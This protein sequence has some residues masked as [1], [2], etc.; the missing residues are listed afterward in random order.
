MVIREFRADDLSAALDL[1]NRSFPTRHTPEWWKWKYDE[2][3]FGK[4]IVLVAEEDGHVIGLRG[5]WR[6]EFL[7]QGQVLKTVQS[8][9]TCVDGEYRRR[10]IF[11][12]LV[13]EALRIAGC[14]GTQFVYNFPGG[15]SLPGYLKLGWHYVKKIGWYVRPLRSLRTLGACLGWASHERCSLDLAAPLGIEAIERLRLSPVASRISTRVS[16]EFLAWRYLHHPM[17]QYGMVRSANG[18]DRNIGIYRLN[19]YKGLREL[20]LVD[21]INFDQETLTLLMKSVIS[22]ARSLQVDYILVPEV[23]VRTMKWTMA[24]YG[25]CLTRKRSFN[26][27][28]R[29]VSDA[30]VEFAYD[31]D[32]WFVTP[33]NVDTY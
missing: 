8:V 24:R 7:Y 22:I 3:V 1:L 19:L 16:H 20:R 30:S 5:F 18:E 33:G 25:F 14:Q 11:T 26:F 31:Y 27:V 15:Q 2:N 4:S 17:F 29:P 23:G 6:W 10:G 13:Q 9:D 28:C 32:N 12:Q 21:I